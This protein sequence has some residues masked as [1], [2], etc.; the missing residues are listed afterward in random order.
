M[1]GL[2][3][4]WNDCCYKK[5]PSQSSH[6]S[7][8]QESNTERCKDF[9]NHL[10]HSHSG[11]KAHVPLILKNCSPIKE[12]EKRQ[13]KES[14]RQ[15]PPALLRQHRQTTGRSDQGAQC[16]ADTRLST[17]PPKTET[18]LPLK[19]QTTTDTAITMQCYRPQS[20]SQ[21]PQN[22]ENRKKTYPLRAAWLQTP[23]Y[24]VIKA[25]TKCKWIC[26]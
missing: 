16:T 10:K 21:L 14:G 12:V 18:C 23:T 1:R 3:L 25:K 19:P 2:S 24:Y 17:R 7:Y 20:L 4:E 13:W 9:K 8:N 22:S 5:H 26:I 6:L 15:T 11:D